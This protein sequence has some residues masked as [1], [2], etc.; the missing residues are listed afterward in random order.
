MPSMTKAGFRVNEPVKGAPKKP[1]KPKKPQAPRKKRKGPG[2]ATVIASVIFLCALLLSAG[3]LYLYMTTRKYASTFMPGL[4]LN[5]ESLEGMTYEEAV[6]RLKVMEM[7]DMADLT[8]AFECGED[9]YPMTV[10]ELGIGYDA[11]ATLDSLYQIGREDNLIRRYLTLQDLKRQPVMARAVVQY[12]LAPAEELLERIR[13]EHTA[14]P[15]SAT[16]SFDPTSSVFFTYTDEAEGMRVNTD[17]A[18][19]RLRKVIESGKSGVAEV[20]TE[21][22]PAGVTRSDLE[23]N[24]LILGR[25][26]M[27]LGSDHMVAENAETA[28][29]QLS[30]RRIEP[31]GQLSF[32]ETVGPRN[33][34]SGYVQAPE[35]AYG[36]DIAG[37]GGGVCRAS[38]LLYQAALLSG[39]EIAERNP[40]AVQVSFTEPGEE[41]TVSDQGLDLIIRNGTD[42]P[43][44]LRCRVFE[45]ETGK[46]ALFEMFGARNFVSITLE[47]ETEV[48]AAPDTPVYLRDST[49]TYARY[50]TDRV[51]RNQAMDGVHVRVTRKIIAADLNETAELLSDDRYEPIPECYWVGT[52]LPEV[53]D[54]MP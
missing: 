1:Q 35:E 29:L 32:N 5:G 39:L 26:Q 28:L 14:E 54:T 45:T 13:E 31:G 11:A 16:V 51:L 6:A 50:Q 30:G 20:P 4:F 24:M 15:V 12:D 23:Q 27:S 7:Q 52:E 10:Q 34:E 33:E 8:Y 42:Y 18:L 19:D 49:G 21:V 46:E 44:F 36:T 3:V 9:A 22:I 53:I 2:K 40:A 37:V 47:H 25:V 43:V 48:L 38:T 41:A 17:G